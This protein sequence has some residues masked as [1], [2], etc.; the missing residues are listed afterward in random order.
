M[1][2]NSAATII[3]DHGLWFDEDKD[4]SIAMI[5]DYERFYRFY[6]HYHRIQY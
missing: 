4:R 1:F 3:D 6:P 2:N 5:G